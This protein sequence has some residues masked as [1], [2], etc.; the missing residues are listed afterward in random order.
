MDTKPATFEDNRGWGIS[1]PYRDPEFERPG[2]DSFYSL[3]RRSMISD[4]YGWTPNRAAKIYFEAWAE[5][6]AVDAHQAWLESRRESSA[7]GL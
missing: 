6:E 1:Y 7:C 2:G 3:A 4:S 5:N